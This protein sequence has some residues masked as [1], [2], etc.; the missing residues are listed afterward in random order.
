[1]SIRLVKLEENSMSAGELLHISRCCESNSANAS[2]PDSSG[3][4]RQ[5][6]GLIRLDVNEAAVSR[7]AKPGPAQHGGQKFKG[8]WELS[9]YTSIHPRCGHS[10]GK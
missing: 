9:A 2:Q 5:V 8:S 1:M 3:S 7:T 6:A 10:S 4:T